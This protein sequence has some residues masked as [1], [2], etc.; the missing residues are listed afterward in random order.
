MDISNNEEKKKRVPFLALLLSIAA[1]GLGHIYCGKLAKGLFLFFI[2]FAF[3]P[4]IANSMENISSIFSLMAVIGSIIILISVFLYAVVDSYLLAKQVGRGYALKEYNRWYVYLLFIVVSVSYPSSLSNHIREDILQAFKIPSVSMVPSI[5]R[6]DY[7]LLNKAIF[8]TQ[9]PTRGDV[10]VF[11]YPNDRHL[12]YI[13]RIV[14]MPGETVE[15]R[16]NVVL[17]N[18]KPL[19]YDRVDSEALSAI[20]NQVDGNVL[21]EVNG[22]VRYKIMVK[23]TDPAYSDFKRITVPNGHCFVLGDNR[24]HSSDSRHFGPVPLADIKGRVD[25]I[26]LPAETWSRFGKYHN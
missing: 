21:E 24:T 14:A 13:K 11:V 18:D 5:L 26:Y 16:N 7:V 23:G 22:D 2:S 9:A 1:T 15:I 25:Y 6:N 3:A 8:K 10:V 17:V 19:E 20:K 12:N 4:I